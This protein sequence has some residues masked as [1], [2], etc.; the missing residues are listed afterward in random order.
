MKKYKVEFLKTQTR[1]YCIDI[2]AKSEQEATDRAT[3]KF[4][5]MEDSDMAHYSETGDINTITEVNHVFDVTNTDDP[6]NP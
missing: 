4:E 2:E 3:V 5:A 6:F 1:T